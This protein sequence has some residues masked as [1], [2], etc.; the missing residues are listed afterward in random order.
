MSALTPRSSV[1]VPSVGG[2]CRSAVAGAAPA[3][4]TCRVWLVYFAPNLDE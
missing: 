2:A 3:L 4:P 1:A